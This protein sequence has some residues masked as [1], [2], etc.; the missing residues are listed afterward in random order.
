VLR[1]A[2]EEV[3]AEGKVLINGWCVVSLISLSLS[4][5]LPLSLS[6]LHR[7]RARILTPLFVGAPT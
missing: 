1:D 5:S 2:V 7:S 4:L 3:I 6:P